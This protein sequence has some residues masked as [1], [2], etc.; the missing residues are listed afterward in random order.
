MRVGSWLNSEMEYGR[1]LADS[2]WQG[3]RAA[4]DSALQ[5]EPVGELLSRSVRNSW[6]PTVIGAGIGALC[7]LL[8]QRRKAANP[9]TTVALGM[10]GG[11]FG[12]AA[13]VAWETRDLS[14]EVAR[15]ALKNM[16]T[17]RDSHWLEKHPI[18]FG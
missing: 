6:A 4:W 13:G 11:L 7:A 5:N 2:G 15:G 16:G 10:A 3:A 8:M 17:A 1:D 14:S 9:M 18:S 12:F